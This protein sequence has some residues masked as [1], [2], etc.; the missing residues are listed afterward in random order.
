M[1]TPTVSPPSTW[2]RRRRRPYL[3]PAP[4]RR[5]RATTRA[6]TRT[7]RRRSAL[8]RC[9]YQSVPPADEAAVSPPVVEG[10]LTAGGRSCAGP[11]LTGARTALRLQRQ[12]PPQFAVRATLESGPL[13]VRRR[14]PGAGASAARG[15]RLLG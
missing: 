9:R 11:P 1:A 15:R 10:V 5:G 7:P 6:T 8:R 13:P 12:N 4:R 2:W 3:V 14:A